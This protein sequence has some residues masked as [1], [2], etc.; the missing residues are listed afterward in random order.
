[1]DSFGST[2]LYD[3]EDF[4]EILRLYLTH[5][6]SFSVPGSRAMLSLV[7][8]SKADCDGLA[9]FLVNCARSTIAITSRAKRRLVDGRS[10]P[11]KRTND[12]NERSL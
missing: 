5:V 3:G 12:S 11:A 4:A 1:M 10:Y 6:D 7:P 8:M 2:T 9:G